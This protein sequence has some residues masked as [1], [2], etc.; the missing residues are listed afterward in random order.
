[1]GNFLP[2]PHFGFWFITIPRVKFVNSAT[3]YGLFCK[4]LHPKLIILSEKEC[5]FYVVFFAFVVYIGVKF[6]Y[7]C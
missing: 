2:H 1:M 7:E 6:Y 5:Y 3:A 4:Q